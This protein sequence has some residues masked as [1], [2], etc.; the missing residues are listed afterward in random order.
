MNIKTNGEYIKINL[1]PSQLTQDTTPTP[2]NPQNIHVIKGINVITLSNSDN[3]KSQN[4][5]ITLSSNNLFDFD[6]IVVSRLGNE[7]TV[8]VENNI[9]TFTATGQSV[10]GVTIDLADLNLKNNTTYTVSNLFTNTGTLAGNTGWRY[11]DGSTYT[12]L[13][14]YQTYFTFTTTESGTNQLL[15]YLGSPVTYTGT[16]TLYNIQ[17]LEGNITQANIPNY[18][19]YIANPIEYCKIGDYEDQ[20]FKNTTDSPYYDNTLV[21]GDW[22]LKK[23]ILKHTF[24]GDSSVDNYLFNADSTNTLAVNLVLNKIDKAVIRVTNIVSLYSNFFSYASNANDDEHLYITGATPITGGYYGNIRL[25]I[26]HSRLN[27]YSS[28]LTNNEK[29][30]L[31]KTWLSQNPLIVYCIPVTPQTIHITETDY[32]I[33][34]QQLEDMYNNAKSYEQETNISQTNDDLPFDITYQ[35]YRK[36]EDLKDVISNINEFLRVNL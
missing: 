28:S 36:P 24:V 30:D 18:L 23:N 6:N 21:E 12:S 8:N 15:Y 31:V 22:Y 19:P 7:G 4:Y 11:Y 34:H 27:G 17:L 20:L 10:Y 2:D 35:L 32:P 16:L 9:I 13:N 14:N 29:R 33:L 1:F 3:S 5:P 25:Y 26:A